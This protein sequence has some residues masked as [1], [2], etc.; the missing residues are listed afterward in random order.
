M[1]PELKAYLNFNKSENYEEKQ[2][3]RSLVSKDELL[4]YYKSERQKYFNFNNEDVDSRKILNS[5]SG[6]YNLTISFFKTGKNNW[7]YSQ[8]KV[9]LNDKLID[10]VNRNYSTFPFLFIENH[11]NGHD[12]LIC[13]EDYQGQ[14]I[15]ELDTGIRKDYFPGQLPPAQGWRLVN[16]FTLLQ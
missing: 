2:K 10:T 9:Y 1:S 14:T 15:I 7:N 6:K 16:S 11:P 3:L 5:P 8:G 12:Y 13:G 4:Q